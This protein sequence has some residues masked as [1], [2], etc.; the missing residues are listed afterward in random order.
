LYFKNF[1]IIE[2][3]NKHPTTHLGSIRIDDFLGPGDV[4]QFDVM[5]IVPFGGNVCVGNMI[6]SDIKKALVAGALNRGGGGYIQYTGFQ[7]PAVAGS[8]DWQYVDE[9]GTPQALQDDEKYV[10][11]VP[12]YLVRGASLVCAVN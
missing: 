11:I 12:A 6:G 10:V 8:S 3:I 1:C 5:R 2:L 7:A 4:T 9:D